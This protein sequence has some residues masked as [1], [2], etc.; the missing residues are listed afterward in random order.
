MSGSWDL[1][2]AIFCRI[3]ESEPDRSFQDFPEHACGDLPQHTST[4]ASQPGHRSALEQQFRLGLIPGG[5]YASLRITYGRRDLFL[6]LT[7]GI[8]GVPN[9]RDEE[10]GLTR[11]DVDTIRRT[12]VAAHLGADEGSTSTRLAT[13]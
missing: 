10:F 7:E 13:G 3:D 6:M 2:D 1:I 11:L 12:T 8:L 9:D 4:I 5:R